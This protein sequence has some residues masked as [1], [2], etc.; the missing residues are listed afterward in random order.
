MEDTLIFAR[1]LRPRVDRFEVIES[2]GTRRPIGNYEM[3]ALIQLRQAELRERREKDGCC[4]E[5]GPYSNGKCRSIG[6]KCPLVL[7][8][9]RLLW[10]TENV[11]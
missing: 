6:G 9:E 7:E 3:Y 11:D 10:R 4:C 8:A 2:D 5:E 1:G